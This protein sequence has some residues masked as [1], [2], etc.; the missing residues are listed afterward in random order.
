MYQDCE[1]MTGLPVSKAFFSSLFFLFISGMVCG[2]GTLPDTVFLAR[3]K[4]YARSL[5]GK[6]IGDQAGLY[7]GVE[8]KEFPFRSKD[9][10]HPF[11]LSD[12]WIGGDVNYD[13]E[14]YQGVSM[15]YDVITD[16]VIVEQPYSYFKLE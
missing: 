6:S 7:N 8:Y 11:Y 2:Q 13:G 1:A 14:E 12:E 16:K 9:E 3:A 5:Y 10:G 15:L 4:A